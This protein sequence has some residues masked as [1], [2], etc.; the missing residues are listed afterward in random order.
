MKHMRPYLLRLLLAAA[1]LLTLTVPAAAEFVP[2][3]GPALPASDLVLLEEEGEQTEDSAAAEESVQLQAAVPTEEEAYEAMMALKDEYYEGR[4]WTNADFYAWKGGIYSGGYGCAAFAFILSDAAF[5]DLPAKMST[6]IVYE[7]LKVGDILRINNDTH[8]VIILEIHDDYVVI[9]EGNY[10]RSIHWGRQLTKAAVLQSDNVMTRYPGCTVVL[11]AGEGTVEPASKKV[12]P[13]APYGELPVPVR[14]GYLFTGWYTRAS[15]G[16]EITADTVVSAS[17]DH[18][19]YAHWARGET[20]SM[21][22]ELEWV[23][24]RDD[25]LL[26]VEGPVSAG[27]PALAASYAEDGRL[28]TADWLTASG[29]GAAT[30]S[31]AASV[32]VFWLRQ[33][34]AP[35]CAPAEIEVP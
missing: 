1:L 26:T 27:M 31:E 12:V 17:Y 14:E 30:H 15:G 10:N 19:L 25:A 23:Y 2:V 24:N 13:G 34:C 32:K 35:V 16:M 4:P 3:E 28:L 7:D 5:G 8:S 6:E 21:G 9:A 29:D 18:Y 20:G 11:D 22:G 33:A